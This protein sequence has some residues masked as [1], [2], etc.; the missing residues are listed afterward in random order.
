MCGEFAH[1]AGGGCPVS[2]SLTLYLIPPE[3][4]LSLALELG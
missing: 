4:G 3:Q 1:E 2:C